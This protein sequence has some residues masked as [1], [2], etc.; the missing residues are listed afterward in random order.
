MTNILSA[1]TVAN[2]QSLRGQFF[3][4]IP[5]KH[6][7]VDGF[8]EE[9]FAQKLAHDFPSLERR[10]VEFEE[11]RSYEVHPKNLRDVSP[12]YEAL[13][14]F[15]AS[16]QFSDWATQVTTI[17]GLTYYAD[18]FGAS[19]NEAFGGLGVPPRVGFSYH[20]K[21]HY[22]RRL[23]L[24][25]FL[26]ETWDDAWGGS[27]EMYSSASVPRDDADKSYAPRFNRCVLFETGADSWYGF[28]PIALPKS[29]ERASC[30]SLAVNFYTRERPERE[31]MSYV[32]RELPSWVHEGTT[33]SAAQIDALQTI[34]RERNELVE[35]RERLT[36]NQ[37]SAVLLGTILPAHE[38][39]TPTVPVLGYV[40]SV[41]ETRG[42]YSDG[43]TAGVF[44]FGV[45]AL[46]RVV[47]FSINAPVPEQLA[48]DAELKIYASN[49][50]IF[51]TPLRRG[52]ELD[53]F[54]PFTLERGLTAE[55]TVY[56]S[57][58]VPKEFGIG[59]DR[60]NIALHMP[61]ITFEH[62]AVDS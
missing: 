18:A 61:R 23:H 36:A 40:E 39:A 52:E 30:K 4:E 45:R 50:L 26:T 48:L 56:C 6:V 25:V 29:A 5:F 33:L 13:D 22:Q 1:E 53:A 12:Q 57:T 35:L 15:F 19:I 8:F 60:R 58:F 51:T 32:P 55:F 17:K 16:E 21:T 3:S 41:G 54:C 47:G 7:L 2:G 49:T 44:H 34:A 43:W 31:A 27:I 20:P 9:T 24:I 46:R 11:R 10:D 28:Q 59:A 38:S 37:D 14:Q 62:D 42:L